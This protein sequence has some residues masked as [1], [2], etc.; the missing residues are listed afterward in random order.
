MSEGIVVG[1]S[2]PNEGDAA[3]LCTLFDLTEETFDFLRD[4]DRVF[5][6]E[7]MVHR[8][9]NEAYLDLN[10]RLRLKQSSVDGTTSDAGVITLPT[11]FVEMMSLWFT[12]TPA[13]VVDDYVFESYSEPATTVLDSNTIL[14]R[15]FGGQ[16]ETYPV[17]ISDDYT[18]RYV[19]RPTLLSANGD[20]PTA[21]TPELCVRL[22]KYALAEAYQK[23]GEGQLAAAAMAEYLEG[24]PGRPRA[25]HRQR[26]ASIDLIPSPGPFG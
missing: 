20:Q 5:V 25:G 21:L 17:V 14:V 13:T 6:T 3:A 22:R 2:N 11:D 9:I 19:A 26:P 7:T 4:T 8:W 10:A 23:E 18:L 15:Y 1:L 24:L 16:F 12:S